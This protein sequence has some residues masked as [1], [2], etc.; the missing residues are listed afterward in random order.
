LYGRLLHNMKDFFKNIRYFFSYLIALWFC[1]QIRISPRF[2]VRFYARIAAGCIRLMPSAL[3][4]CT[5]NIKV[6]FPEWDE[7]RIHAVAVKSI[8]LVALNFLEFIWMSGIP[9]RIERVCKPTDEAMQKIKKYVEKNV[10]IIFVNPHLGS[11]EASGLMAPYYT[12]LEMAAIAKPSRNKYLNKLISGRREKTGGLKIIFA[13][14]AMKAAIK[15]LRSNMSIGTLIDQNTRVRD[16]GEFVEFFGLPAPSSTAPALLKRY[17]DAND[18]P[19][20]ILYGTCVRENNSI[21]SYVAELAKPFDEYTCDRE[22]IQDLMHMTESFIRRYPEQYVWLYKRFRYIPQDA[23]E[24]AIKRFP[25]YAEKVKPV[26]Y[27]RMRGKR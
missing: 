27:S 11:W 9:R 15:A 7:K 14:G 22:V 21:V 6:A 17:C 8:R 13:K 12:G 16:G 1:F 5:G 26:F 4:I 2:M 24:D 23:D 20:V 25:Y 18:I 19:A 10:R 3:K